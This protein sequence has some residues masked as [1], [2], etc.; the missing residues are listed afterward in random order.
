VDVE[1]RVGGEAGE[2]DKE[3]TVVEMYYIRE[4]RKRKKLAI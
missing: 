4:Q 2:R 3:E 1:E